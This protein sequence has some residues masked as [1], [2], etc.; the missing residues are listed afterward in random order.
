MA[1]KKK[2]IENEGSITEILAELI[3]ELGNLEIDD[4]DKVIDDIFDS[5]KA[6]DGELIDAMDFLMSRGITPDKYA[7]Y[8]AAFQMAKTMD[9]EE[10]DS[11]EQIPSELT[12]HYIRR[13]GTKV[14]AYTPLKDAADYSLLLKIQMK[15]VTKPPMWRELEVPADMNFSQLHEVIQVVMG[16]ENYHMWQF[17]KT[18]DDDSLLISDS[19]PEEVDEFEVTHEASETPLTMFLQ[20]R[21]DKLEYTYDFGDDWIFTVEVKELIKGRLQHPV[22]RKFKSE[23]NPIEDFGGIW[24]Y[25]S[26]RED[27]ET[28]EKLTKKQRREHAADHGFDSADKY[29]DYLSF[30]LIDPEN[31]NEEL[32]EH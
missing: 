13:Q 21:K 26:A 16:F 8:Y 29:I 25:I 7:V 20:N 31:V 23:L 30:N 15:D 24:S 32:E 4:Y 28:W 22:C 3:P 17:N 14:M 19:N 2:I 6:F 11:P 9:P 12:E 27:L 1:K 5:S 18:A 10:L